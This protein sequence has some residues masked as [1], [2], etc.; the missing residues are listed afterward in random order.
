[1]ASLLG[2]LRHKRVGRA[3]AAACQTSANPTQLA[4]TRFST[5][6]LEFISAVIPLADQEV[7]MAEASGSKGDKPL[8]AAI[9]QAL[10]QVKLQVDTLAFGSI[11]ITIH[12][13]KVVQLEVLEKRR[14]T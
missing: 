9:Q 4:A 7:A 10:E 11:T 14:L 3:S 1:V 6:E 2:L 13:R 12:D 5:V 8:F